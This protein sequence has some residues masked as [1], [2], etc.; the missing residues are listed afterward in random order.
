[1][2]NIVAALSVDTSSYRPTIAGTVHKKFVKTPQ[3][4]RSKGIGCFIGIRKIDLNRLNCETMVARPKQAKAEEERSA[5]TFLKSRFGDGCTSG[6]NVCVGSGNLRMNDDLC[7][8]D[9]LK[10][11]EER[12]DSLRGLSTSRSHKNSRE[13]PQEEGVKDSG[14]EVHVD[15]SFEEHEHDLAYVSKK[16]QMLETST[17]EDVVF[18]TPVDSSEPEPILCDTKHMVGS[19]QAEE[20]LSPCASRASKSDTD[21]SEASSDG[22]SDVN[23]N[24]P[25]LK[26]DFKA[27]DK[28][29]TK[30]APPRRTSPA[31]S[32]APISKSKEKSKRG[33][34]KSNHAKQSD[35]VKLS[36]DRSL[37]S[38]SADFSVSTKT[39]RNTKKTTSMVEDQKEV[40]LSVPK[41]PLY[42]DRSLASMSAD[43][44]VPTNT[45]TVV[46]RSSSMEDD[47]KRV[48]SPVPKDAL[49]FSDSA[50]F[51]FADELSEILD[52]SSLPASRRRS[53]RKKNR[54]PCHDRLYHSNKVHARQEEG[55]LRREAI[56]RAS[57]KKRELPVFSDETI[58]LSKATDFYKKSMKQRFE[59]ERKLAEKKQAAEDE[60]ERAIP[61]FNETIPFANASDF[62]KKSMRKAHR[63]KEKIEDKK[64]AA[65]QKEEE[66]ICHGKGAGTVPLSQAG[67]FY[68]KSVKWAILEE[69]RR[70]LSAR[71]RKSNYEPLYKFNLMK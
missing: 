71:E 24:L 31:R 61:K 54:V 8:G 52:T 18:I 46:E 11:Y 50:S 65:A 49:S 15:L 1:M 32:R 55:R 58:P 42:Q 19:N 34:E 5:F 3:K 66:V 39:T 25:P 16:M 20:D 40:I 68:K 63:M 28:I 48:I 59:K 29:D 27:L 35:S 22:A 60:R 57:A 67:N 21:E 51:S 53:P 38:L 7:S 6:E 36:Q 10:R 64:I 69:R 41:E 56:A 30:I 45:P 43:F 37:E 2:N 44:P 12:D 26:D 4:L 47:M 62:Y 70:A 23:E 14:I 33:S 9:E 13:S 17:S